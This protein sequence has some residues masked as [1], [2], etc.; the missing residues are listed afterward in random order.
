MFA[1]K[2]RLDDIKIGKKETLTEITYQKM[3]LESFPAVIIMQRIGKILCFTEDTMRRLHRRCYDNP[4]IA[5]RMF[6]RFKRYLGEME[7]R[8]DQRIPKEQLVEYFGGDHKT[9]VVMKGTFLHIISTFNICQ[10]Y[11]NM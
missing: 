9:D 4:E 2:A 7:K 8:T 10:M 1:K 5:M 3:K 11:E 6:D